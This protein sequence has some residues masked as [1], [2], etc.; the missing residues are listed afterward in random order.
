MRSC[1]SSTSQR[2]VQMQRGRTSKLTFLRVSLPFM[3]GQIVQSQGA[4]DGSAR[5]GTRRGRTLSVPAAFALFSA[6]RGKAWRS[7]SMGDGGW[8]C[9]DWNDARE[10]VE[11]S[12]CFRAFLREERKS[13]AFCEYGGRRR[14]CADWNA[15]GENV[16][17]GVPAVSMARRRIERLQ[18][19]QFCRR[20]MEIRSEVSGPPDCVRGAW[21]E[22]RGV[23]AP[24]DFWFGRAGVT[25]ERW[26]KG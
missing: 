11:R 22:K 1:F 5:I 6:K 10:N 26:R 9:V 8:F 15:A 23:F 3:E 19:V 14:F 2:A 21:T 18:G 7:A 4:A 24:L 20:T 13:V 25:A 17:A 12:G 16:E